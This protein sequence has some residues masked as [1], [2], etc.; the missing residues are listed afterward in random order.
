[1]IR[2]EEETNGE[3]DNG[4]EAYYPSKWIAPLTW[5]EKLTIECERDE[6]AGEEINEWLWLLVN[7]LLSCL[8]QWSMGLSGFRSLIACKWES[9]EMRQCSGRDYKGGRRRRWESILANLPMNWL[10]K[11]VCDIFCLEEVKSFVSQNKRIWRRKIILSKQKLLNIVTLI[12]PALLF[13]RCPNSLPP[14]VHLK[15]QSSGWLW[16]NL[17]L[18]PTRWAGDELCS[19]MRF[20]LINWIILVTRLEEYRLLPFGSRS[21]SKPPPRATDTTRHD[22]VEQCLVP[23]TRPTESDQRTSIIIVGAISILNRNPPPPPQNSRRTC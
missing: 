14:S 20:P 12:H 17:G 10:E 13:S 15:F 8:C 18:T 16:Q 23:N 3:W 11:V 19:K 21:N 2:T 5:N 4:Y 7:T 1:M 6:A 9:S 22:N